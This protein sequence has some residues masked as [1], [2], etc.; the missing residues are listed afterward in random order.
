[1]G[2][3]VSEVNNGAHVDILIL[4]DKFF[5]KIYW[6]G[7]YAI[8]NCLFL[9]GFKTFIALVDILDIENSLLHNILYIIIKFSHYD[10]PGHK[11]CSS[12]WKWNLHF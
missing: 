1:M 9:T 8:D 12:H 3:M 11:E 7:I 5:H 4:F 2:E 10:H 6:S